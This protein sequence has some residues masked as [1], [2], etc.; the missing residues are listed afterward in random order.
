M[1]VNSVKLLVT[2]IS[3]GMLAASTLAQSKS[4][5][6][7]PPAATAKAGAPKIEFQSMVYDFGKVSA[8]ELVKHEFVF[9]N[10][11]KAT[12]EILDVR[13]GC[14]CTTAGTW[15]KKVEP[16]KTGIIPLQFNSA[17][18][19]GSVTKQATVLCNDPASSNLVLQIKGTVW[20]P[21]DVSPTMAFFSVSSETQTNETKVVRIVNQLEQPITLSDLQLNNSSF[22]ADLKTIKPGKEFELHVTAVPPFTNSP[23]MAPITLKTSTTNMPTINVTA[24]VVVQ[25]AVVVTP[26]QLTIP[27]GPLSAPMSLSVGIRNSGTNSLTLSDAKVNAPGAEVR[28]QEGVPGKVFSLM[29]NLPTGFNIKPEQKVEL[30]VKSNHPKYPL[31]TVPFYQ[32]QPPVSVPPAQKTAAAQVVPAK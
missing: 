26:T 4:A 3:F 14:G 17:G 7:T 27:Q 1:R 6:A 10:S 29:V 9:T 25:Q 20:K 19:G 22:L 5:P 16:G 23:I 11:G 18:F 12:L 13:P 31:I 2:A 21:I 24:Y 8:N 15:D 30:T 32:T 28:V